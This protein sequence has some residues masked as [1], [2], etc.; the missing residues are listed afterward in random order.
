[1][2]HLTVFVTVG[3]DYHPFDRL[4][5]W[6]DVAHVDERFPS[7]FVQSG[8]SRSPRHAPGSPYLDYEEMIAR[9][10]DAVAIVTHG[11]PATIIQARQLGK[12]PIVV[13]RRAGKGE[14]VDDHQWRFAQRLDQKGDAVLVESE[15]AFRG[16]IGRLT[17]QEDAFLLRSR[18]TDHRDAALLEFERQVERLMARRPAR[19]A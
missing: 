10:R 14:H 8:T 4:V 17:D 3:T 1:M 9:M 11:G 13:P 15:P 18:K 19:R 5:E 12:L 16:A 6:T 2:K 7:F